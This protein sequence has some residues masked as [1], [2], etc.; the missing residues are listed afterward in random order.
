VIAALPALSLNYLPMAVGIDAML[1]V[2]KV[3][4]ALTER[5]YADLL[6]VFDANGRMTPDQ[7]AWQLDEAKTEA[8]MDVPPTKVYDW[9][10]LDQ[11][12]AERGAR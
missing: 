6:P 7:I 8:G 9:S 3:E 5:L 1:N 10:L 12:L 4:P 11:V 2:L